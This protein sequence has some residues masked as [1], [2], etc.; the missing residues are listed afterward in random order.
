MDEKAIDLFKAHAEG[1]LPREGGCIV[2]SFFHENSAYAKYEI[3]AYGS[4]IGVSPS[5]E[6]LIFLADGNKLF[7]LSEPADY[8]RKDLEP[9]ARDDRHQ[10]PHLFSEVDPLMARNLT[11]I[12][13]SRQPVSTY[14]SFVVPR[15]T[16][17]NFSI[18]FYRLPDV[19]DSVSAYFEKTL[20]ERANVPAEDA[21]EAARRIVAGLKR[22]TIWQQ[23]VAQ[24]PPVAAPPAPKKTEAAPKPDAR[25]PKAAKRPAR[26]PAAKK[27]AAKKPAARKLKAKK[28]AAKKPAAKKAAARK[29]AA[30]KP[31]VKKPAARK[32]K[33]KKPAAKKR[34]VKKAAR[35]R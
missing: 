15:P 18:L 24:A 19:Y 26:K 29:P 34:A 11:R 20:T 10:I 12:M 28:P 2:T 7:V 35:R 25:R 32:L 16:N 21:A 22:F 6:G 3:V 9:Y 8:E 31:A 17:L 30:R 33:A 1:Q 23:L 14:T 5:E 27:P 4:M 13:I